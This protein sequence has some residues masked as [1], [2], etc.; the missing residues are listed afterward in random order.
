MQVKT[1]AEL[2]EVLA[3]MVKDEGDDLPIVVEVCV[4]D[5]IE[6]YNAVEVKVDLRPEYEPNRTVSLIKPS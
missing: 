3:K 2:I 4:D 6:Q 5:D 1:A